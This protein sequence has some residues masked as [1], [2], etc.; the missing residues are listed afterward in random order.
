MPPQAM[1]Q[2]YACLKKLMETKEVLW[3]TFEVSQTFTSVAPGYL[4]TKQS[5]SISSLEESSQN[6]T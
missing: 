6:V 2:W 1:T 3:S 5:F 4:S